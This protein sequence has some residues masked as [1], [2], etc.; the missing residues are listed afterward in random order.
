MEETL[1]PATE[2][3]VSSIRPMD[4]GRSARTAGGLPKRGA[5]MSP[6]GVT[7]GAEQTPRRSARRGAG[8]L[9]ALQRGTQSA[10]DTASFDTQTPG[11]SENA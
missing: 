4:T 1:P 8:S 9:A 5:R 6:T 10:R 11:G 2:A 3:P 7:N